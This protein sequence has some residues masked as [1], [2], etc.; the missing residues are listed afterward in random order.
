MLEAGPPPIEAI[1]VSVLV[2]VVVTVLVTLEVGVVH[3]MVAVLLTVL[4]IVHVA[5]A[6][7]MR[8]STF[9]GVTRIASEPPTLGGTSFP[10]S[11]NTSPSSYVTMNSATALFT[12][13][14]IN[15]GIKQ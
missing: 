5:L 11:A 13:P 4:V 9:V 3:L 15:S 7:G 6:L 8:S 2:V 14:G 12:P 10:L 1:L